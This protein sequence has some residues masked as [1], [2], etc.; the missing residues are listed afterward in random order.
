MEPALEMPVRKGR[1]KT[2]EARY[3]NYEIYGYHSVGGRMKLDIVVQIEAHNLKQ[4]EVKGEH[5]CTAFGYDYSHANK[6]RKGKW[7]HLYLCS[8]W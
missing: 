1:P 2:G 8:L 6:E 4:A 7:H 3:Q 5:F